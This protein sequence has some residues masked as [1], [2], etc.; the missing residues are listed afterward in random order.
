MRACILAIFVM[1]TIAI[2]RPVDADRA[3]QVAAAR[4]A[5][6]DAAPAPASVT[7]AQTLEDGS[8]AL[9]LAT[10]ERGGF[11]FIRADDN[12]P[13]VAGWS[14]TGT[15]P[16]DQDGAMHPALA[17][18]LDLQRLDAAW[19]RAAGWRHPEAAAAWAA[20][21][22]GAAAQREGETVTPMLSCS[23]DQGWPWNQYCPADAAGPGG[24]VWA[25][26]VATAMAQIMHFWQ[27]PD[28]GAGQH[29]YQ[30]PAYGTQSADFGAT[31]YGWDTMSDAVG[32]PA[33]AL[34]QYHCG[35]AVE[36]QYSPSGSGA[37]V[38]TNHPNALTALESHFRYPAGAEFIQHTQFPGAAWAARL[39]E[40]ILAGR[41][42]LDSGYGSG[43]HAF[44]LD[45]LQDGLFHVNWG[46]SGWFNGWFDI[47]A[48]SPGGMEFSI[49]QGAIV[50]LMRPEI[51]LI[52]LPAQ[53]TAA[54]Q[55][56]P[57]LQLD[58]WVE[59]GPGGAADLMWWA[60]AEAPLD[61]ALDEE[62]RTLQVAYPAGW[63]GG[64]GLSLCAISGVGL[65]SC[66]EIP[67]TV[68]GILPPSPVQDLALTLTPA[69]PRLSWTP[70]TTDSAGQVIQLSA[71]RIHRSMGPFFP[72]RSENLIAVVTP[73]AT[74]WTDPAPPEGLGFYCVVAVA[75]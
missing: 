42:V 62:A 32:T 52:T 72:P 59:A 50:N 12:L 37:W 64:A 61:V 66:A 60:E 41:P 68:Q 9:W 70:P 40:E 57:L 25:G 5:S 33:A 24:H 67:F 14:A 44:V 34:L 16:V 3:A 15:V 55:P 29:S 21:E 36:M 6:G 54:G 26:C 20:L 58:D 11:A 18:W 13:P 8:P 51:P 65:W 56:F 2:A 23:W 75:E 4:L 30:H 47:E 74:F 28:Q 17:D 71:I 31:A 39:G 46:W 63:T 10:F 27:W 69:G 1:T 38:G 35:V 48:L 49:F 45:G 22:S 43:G 53:A 73:E 19:T 7:P